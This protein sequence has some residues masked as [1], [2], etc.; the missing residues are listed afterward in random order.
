MFDLRSVNDR[1][2]ES[3]AVDVTSQLLLIKMKDDNVDIDDI[4]RFY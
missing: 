2:F 4:S 1:I 3:L